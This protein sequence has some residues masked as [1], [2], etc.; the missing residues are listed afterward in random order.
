MQNPACMMQRADCIVHLHG[1]KR[2]NPGKFRG[3]GVPTDD[4]S[5]PRRGTRRLDAGWLYLALS[6]SFLKSPVVASIRA[7][8]AV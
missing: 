7:F 2:L 1:L 8:G 5:D 3:S 6:T 4:G